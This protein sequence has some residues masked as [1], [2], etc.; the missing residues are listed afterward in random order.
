[1]MV[2]PPQALLIPLTKLTI[3]VANVVAY[4]VVYGVSTVSDQPPIEI[5]KG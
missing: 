2:V 1:M 4:S 3:F 5:P